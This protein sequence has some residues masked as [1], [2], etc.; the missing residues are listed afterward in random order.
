MQSKNC[1]VHA[2]LRLPRSRVTHYPYVGK[3]DPKS[4]EQQSVVFVL[5]PI[6]DKAHHIVY[7]SVRPIS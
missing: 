1:R 6:R 2:V 4:W 3:L 7:A 5:G